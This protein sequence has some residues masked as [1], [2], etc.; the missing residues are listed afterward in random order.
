MKINNNPFD[1]DSWEVL[2]RE[3]QVQKNVWLT[4]F[5]PPFHVKSTA[6]LRSKMFYEKLVGQFPT[7]ARYWRMYIEQE[8]LLA[9]DIL[10]NCYCLVLSIHCQACVIFN[11]LLT[12]ILSLEHIT[13]MAKLEYMLIT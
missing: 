12:L 8:V 6:P 7:S 4:F 11:P 9:A 10:C 1:I 2:L 3:A 5:I 13:L